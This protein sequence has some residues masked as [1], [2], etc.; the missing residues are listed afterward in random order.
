MGTEE[1]VF[2]GDIEAADGGEQ[3]DDS[4]A[5]ANYMNGQ[6]QPSHYWPNGGKSIPYTISSSFGEL[7]GSNYSCWGRLRFAL[8]VCILD[9]THCNICMF[10]LADV[11]LGTEDTLLN[12]ASAST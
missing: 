12:I 9:Y 8:E 2:Q 4:D 11:Q 1:G 6:L 10:T 7:V 3:S 5:V